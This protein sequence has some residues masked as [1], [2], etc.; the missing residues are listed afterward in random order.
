MKAGLVSVS[1]RPHSAEEI[2]AAAKAENL[3][4][5]EWGSDIHAPVFDLKKIEN[6]ATL[7]RENDIS[8]SYGSYFKF[9]QTPLRELPNYLKAAQVLGANILRVWCGV[10]SSKDY[11]MAELNA[12]YDD[13]KRASELAEKAGIVLCTECHNWTLTDNVESALSLF[14]AVNSP[15]FQTFWQPNQFKSFEENLAYAKA[16]APITKTLHVFA[17]E[18]ENRYPLSKHLEIWKKYISC[19]QND[20]PCLLEFMPNDKI[21]SLKQEAKSLFEICNNIQK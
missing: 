10:K 8:C 1:F 16:V 15:A 3:T 19:F 2:I 13:C 11:T 7:C 9:G 4:H 20:M 6:I 12:L 18:K 21:S 14:D 17:W 5:I